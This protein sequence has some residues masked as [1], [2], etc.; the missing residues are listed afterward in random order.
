M[1][2]KSCQMVF[3]PEPL[4]EYCEEVFTWPIGHF[5]ISGPT[6]DG[7]R[8][9]HMILPTDR[10]RGA[11]CAI[12]IKTGPK[13][14]GAWAWDG[15]MEKPTLTPSVFHHSTPDWHGFITAGVMVGC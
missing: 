10:E 7:T 13:E 12:P 5:A 2:Y 14:T 4:S 15:N 11:Y 6:A 3:H 1:S 9:I 8:Y